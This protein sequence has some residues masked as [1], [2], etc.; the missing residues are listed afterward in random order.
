M[1]Q[2]FITNHCS[3]SS[4]FNNSCIFK[5]FQVLGNSG[6]RYTQILLNLGNIAFIIDQS[7]HNLQSYWISQRPHTFCQMFE[8]LLQM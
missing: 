3:F 5:D 7:L 8:I 2:H 6:L 1:I 4:A